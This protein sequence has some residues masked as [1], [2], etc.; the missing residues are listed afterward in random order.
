MNTDNGLYVVDGIDMFDGYRAEPVWT[1]PD[2]Y[3]TYCSD[4]IDS[5]CS[6][7]GLDLEEILKELGRI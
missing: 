1:L 3:S 4:E 2:N 5:Q 7:P 6:I